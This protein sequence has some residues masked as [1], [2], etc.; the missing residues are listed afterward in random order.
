MFP[1]RDDDEAENIVNYVLQGKF[2]WDSTDAIGDYRFG[3]EGN[4]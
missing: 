1:A 2:S 4:P 3:E